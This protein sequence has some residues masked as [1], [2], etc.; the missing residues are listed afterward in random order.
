MSRS[1]P[2]KDPSCPGC[3]KNDPPPRLRKSIPLLTPDQ[4]PGFHN[5]HAVGRGKGGTQHAAALPSF[6][7]LPTP[8]LWGP[9]PG[10][11][12]RTNF[13]K[14]PRAQRTGA[15]DVPEAKWARLLSRDRSPCSPPR[16]GGRDARVPSPASLPSPLRSRAGKVAP[17][18]RRRQKEKWKLSVAPGR[19]PR[20]LGPAFASL[21][22]SLL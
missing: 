4:E 10:S 8:T 11:R 13:S 7:G 18:S 6:S 22:P 12:P 19:S 5:T 9:S 2:S 17:V 3:R 1:V 16:S 20:P 15:I 21:L 14:S